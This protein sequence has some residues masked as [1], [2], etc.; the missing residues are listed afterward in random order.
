MTTRKV[1]TY[2]SVVL[3][4]GVLS[5]TLAWTVRATFGLFYVA[6]VEEFGWSR[7]GGSTGYAVSWLM[8]AVFSPLLGWAIDRW[9]VKTMMPL[10]ALA[11]AAALVLSATVQTQWQY[12][13]FFGVI[14]AAGIG[15]MMMSNSVLIPRWFRQRRG[16]ALG[17]VAVGYSI[18]PFLLFRPLSDAIAD[19]GWRTTLVGYAAVLAAFAPIALLLVRERPPSTAASDSSSGPT[20]DAAQKA[21]WTLRDALR[22]RRYWALFVLYFL[23]VV[24]FQVLAT[25]QV[26]HADDVGLGRDLSAPVFGFLSGVTMVG[27]LAG[28][29]VSD[30]L[31]RESVFFFGSVFGTLGV[32]AFAFM[33]NAGGLTSA[34]FLFYA[35]SNGVG[36]G[37][38]L[39]LL[40]AI[41]ADVF[42]GPN[43][44]RILGTF[45]TANALGGFIGPLLGGYIFDTTQSYAIAMV[46]SAAALLGSGSLVWVVAPRKGLFR[47]A[48]R[49]PAT[50]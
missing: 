21:S 25:H 19:V 49:V 24:S 35:L 46:V 43:F 1:L 5:L 29:W 13:L 11:L 7:T 8:L 36:F 12:V 39:S 28:G 32:L 17:V 50:V 47:Q 38:R 41:G 40:T 34:L 44:A 42:L 2:G 14:G 16:A 4:I 45:G 37:I 30:K 6:M 48:Q 15:G 3:A 31:G 26:A 33:G 10:G 9:G 23:G 27:S 20:P 22:S 18:G